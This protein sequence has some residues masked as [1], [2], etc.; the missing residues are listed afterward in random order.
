MVIGPGAVHSR[1][2]ITGTAYVI[3]PA[4]ATITITTGAPTI[5]ISSA[6]PMPPG[7]GLS[8]ARW[9]ACRRVLIRELLIWYGQA[10]YA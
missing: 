5:E 8:L 3:R 1:A 7:L 6:G 4:A 10:D 9:V 2:T